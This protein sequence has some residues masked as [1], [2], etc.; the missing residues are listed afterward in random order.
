MRTWLQVAGM[1]TKWQVPQRRAAEVLVTRTLSGAERGP[2]QVISQTPLGIPDLALEQAGVR[3]GRSQFAPAG[4]TCEPKERRWAVR[5]TED[6]REPQHEV[7]N[8]VTLRPRCTVQ[9]GYRRRPALVATVGHGFRRFS[10]IFRPADNCC[11]WGS[12][13]QKTTQLTGLVSIPSFS[14]SAVGK[15]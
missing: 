10:I 6:T 13:L 12:G 11:P 7:G 5:K 14:R 2:R 15:S 1:V 4:P 9:G 3:A 8:G